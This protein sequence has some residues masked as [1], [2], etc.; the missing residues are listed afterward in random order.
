MKDKPNAVELEYTC[1]WCGTTFKRVVGKVYGK[2][3]HNGSDQV[4]CPKCSNVLRT[5][6]DGK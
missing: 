5:W 6:E 2:G 3:K 1:L 4:K